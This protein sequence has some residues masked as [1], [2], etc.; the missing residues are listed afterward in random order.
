MRITFSNFRLE[1]EQNRDVGLRIRKLESSISSLETDLEGIQKTMSERKETAE[2]I[3]NEINNWK[4]EMGGI[5][6]LFLRKS[7][8]LLSS[9]LSFNLS[10]ILS[11]QFEDFVR[12]RH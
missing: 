4:K 2:K 6:I 7:D 9:V 11:C 12:S 5:L 10:A 3:T 1:Y 8:G